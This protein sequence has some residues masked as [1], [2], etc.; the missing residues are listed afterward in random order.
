M[1]PIRQAFRVLSLVEE[2]GLLVAA[3][4][5]IRFNTVDLLPL[6]NLDNWQKSQ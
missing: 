4:S 5:G 6:K 3:Y 2:A 1:Q